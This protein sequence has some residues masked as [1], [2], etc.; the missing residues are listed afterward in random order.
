MIS[1][2]EKYWW[3]FWRSANM[4]NCK[5]PPPP[6]KIRLCYK[7]YI[8]QLF[9]KVKS[10]ATP[11]N[12]M[13]TLTSPWEDYWELFQIV[14]E[15]YCHLRKKIRKSC[16]FTQLYKRYNASSKDSHLSNTYRLGGL[17]IPSMPICILVPRKISV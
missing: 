5:P 1:H 14:L 15:S 6:L 9:Q 16:F 7:A 3:I 10:D 12:C 11:H 17:K 4:G 8:V 2:Q 13:H